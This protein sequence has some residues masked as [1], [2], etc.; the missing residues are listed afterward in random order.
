M[1]ENDVTQLPQQFNEEPNMFSGILAAR[2][3]RKRYET[4][5]EPLKYQEKVDQIRQFTPT[6][7]AVEDQL[8]Q[9]DEGILSNIGS[10]LSNFPIGVA[11][12]LGEII[13]TFG[14]PDNV[15][16]INKAV[17]TG[18]SLGRDTGKFMS[19]FIPG[20]GIA[21]KGLKLMNVLA[22]SNKLTRA[23]HTVS[24]A[25]AGAFADAAA[26]DP[27]DPTVGNLMLNLGVISHD[28]KAGALVKEWFAQDD[29]DPETKA[30][31]KAALS[32]LLA[33]AAL[34]TV[35]RTAAGSIRAV[36]K[37]GHV[38]NVPIKEIEDAVKGGAEETVEFLEHIKNTGTKEDIDK[39]IGP[40]A[41]PKGA[42]LK[43][44]SR[45]VNSYDKMFD[46]LSPE[47]QD[48]MVK[49]FNGINK[50]E[51][52]P[53]QS[54]DE[55]ISMN[56]TKIDTD[57]ERQSI[58]QFISSKIDFDKIKPSIRTADLNNT[59]ALV[60]LLEVDATEWSRVLKEHGDNVKEAI[61]FT[62]SSKVLA[63]VTQRQTLQASK[64]YAK[65][66]NPEDLNTLKH[67]I[68]VNVDVLKAGGYLSKSAS[69][70][71][72]SFKKSVD[73]LDS[74]K[75]LRSFLLNDIVNVDPE[76]SV[77][78]AARI[79]VLDELDNVK[80]STR[81]K[82]GIKKSSTVKKKKGETPEN[83][84]KRLL[85]DARKSEIDEINR[86]N[87]RQLKARV[88]GR[89]MS[90]KAKTRD[91]FLEVYI[92]GLLSSFKTTA[93]NL[94][95]NSTAIFTSIMDRAYA[96]AKTSI[97]GEGEVTA[98]E[99]SHLAWGYLSSLKDLPSLMKK[100]WDLDP[101]KVREI[102]QDFLR[103]H[104][105]ALS[106]EMFAT[107][108]MLGK[109]IDL[110]GTAVNFPGRILLTAD[111]VFKSV[112]YRAETRALSYR[113]ALAEIGGDASSIAKKK[114]LADRFNAIMADL[115]AHDDITEAANG[116]SAKNTFT[117]KLPN[118]IEKDAF[119]NDVVKQG[120]GNRLKSVI[121]ADPTGIVRV[122]IPFF[123]TPAN[124][125]GF[126]WERTPILRKLNK[127]LQMELGSPN[128]GIR[129][130]AEAKVA[131]ANIM[132]GTMFAMAMTGDFTGAPPADPDIRKS[133]EA[134]MGGRFWYSYKTEDGWVPYDRFDP[135]AIMMAASANMT[136]M[137]KASMNLAGQLEDGDPSG[138]IYA[139]YL[140]TMQANTVGLTRLI[141]DRHYLQ[142]F[143]ELLDV[144]TVQDR[145]FMETV[146][147]KLVSVLDPRV[148]F[149]SSLQRNISTG[150]NPVKSEKGQKGDIE[151]PW[152]IAKE[153]NR[154]NED[155]L[156]TTVFGYGERP[157]QKNLV[158]EKTLFPGTNE[159]LD[160]DVFS[161][162]PNLASALFK[163]VAAATQSKSAL[164]NKIGDLEMKIKQPS[165]INRVNGVL[166]TDEEKSYMVDNWT[167]FN[168]GLDKLVSTKSFNKFPE[169]IQRLIIEN[170]INDNK[171]TAKK[172]TI[173]KFTRL[174]TE[175][176]NNVK[177]KV[178]SDTLKTVPTS[179]IQQLLQGKQ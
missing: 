114:E 168:K 30:R 48:E 55:I 61:K 157:A 26:F 119:G 69:D 8:G 149:Y 88:K 68:Q 160:S 122:F 2:E 155:A 136:I 110:L 46:K 10:A 96:A 134:K 53:D 132:W 45:E 57:V 126:A 104:D 118:F 117:N 79:G 107:G 24:A 152:D 113:K 38:D 63:E 65:S 125:L 116:F 178:N 103:P 67:L 20:V 120:I 131:T 91:A 170:V 177:E 62:G 32:G 44:L 163:P 80:I 166:L 143:S 144:I 145:S 11:E 70:L 151:T 175:M 95:G 112:N 42:M 82:G 4:S 60:D 74:E 54:L 176:F 39:F 127:T 92:N 137:A 141:S 78:N 7:N 35:I 58:L 97:K 115:S 138:E 169:G 21:G 147:K 17:G 159:E 52:I 31:L 71:L 164:I 124:L 129:E 5:S 106:K 28:S 27:K 25:V 34:D 111:E 99:F 19:G 12:G 51:T 85:E 13:Q 33:G 77:K 146:G 90:F 100:G 94:T 47:K 148:S 41:T 76:L 22:K 167:K 14:G 158:G 37:L 93:I 153:L 150:L 56:F 86:A 133:L 101:N 81:F 172:L 108:G 154:I 130:M 15:F 16:N 3:A 6:A 40:L 73:P 165:S 1:P 18:A 87:L 171:T 139:K 128:A 142:G 162:L 59:G 72:R 102:K 49:V 23:G 109:A 64:V 105:R 89:A 179:P 98:K 50:G 83:F 156:N 9:D 174:S 29:N 161:V 123:Q 43:H 66:G 84:K 140:E 121:D 173:A 75:E 135:L 36:R